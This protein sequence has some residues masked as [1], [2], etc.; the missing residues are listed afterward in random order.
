MKCGKPKS[1]RYEQAEQLYRKII[2]HDPALP[3][4]YYALARLQS[5]QNQVDNALKRWNR[6]L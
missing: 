6:Q 5:I 4:A 2:Q 1:H 3:G